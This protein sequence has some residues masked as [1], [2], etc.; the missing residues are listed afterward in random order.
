VRTDLPTVAVVRLARTKEQQ[1]RIGILGTGTLAAGLGAGWSRAGHEVVVA[2]RSAGKARALADRLGTGVR[3]ATPAEA[4][5]GAGAVLLAV[6]WEG[7]EDILRLAVPLAGAVLIDPTNPVEHGVGVVRVAGGG[8]AA[9]RIAELT[10]GARVVK[11]FHLFPADRWTDPPAGEPP[12][13]VAMC[14]DD[15][16]ALRVAG[17]LVRAVGAVP[18]VLGPLHRARQLEEVAGFVIGLAFAGVDPNAAIPRVPTPV[19]G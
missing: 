18:A 9:E 11:A 16:D 2:G 1:V 5:A 12:V 19:A 8:S 6:A 10:P 7:V 4:V 13:T 15:P 17:E 3:A 14:G